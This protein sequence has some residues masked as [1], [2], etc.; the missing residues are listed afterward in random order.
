MP[1]LHRIR[2]ER[3]EREGKGADAIQHYW[4]ALS[5]RPYTY[6]VRGYAEAL[7]K[8]VENSD[9]HADLAQ[10]HGAVEGLWQD[11][12][13]NAGIRFGDYGLPYQSCSPAFIPGSRDT[14]ERLSAY[15]LKSLTAGARV[16]DIGCNVGFLSLGLA[17][18]AQEVIGIDNDRALI[19]I[20]ER[21]RDYLKVSN[22]IWVLPSR[23]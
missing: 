11:Y 17:D 7:K 19:G 18:G 10:L 22:C 21:V 20:A 13:K 1:T 8:A 3:S 23:A 5:C 6:H 16:L 4:R 2:A 15:D 14:D 9:D 12:R